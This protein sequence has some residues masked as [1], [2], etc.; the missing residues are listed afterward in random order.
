MRAQVQNIDPVLFLQ[1]ILSV[2]LS[3]GCLVY[4]WRT[5]RFR[6]VV[7]GLSAVAYWAAI[8]VKAVV[9]YASV[10]PVTSLYG[11]PSIQLALLLGMQTVVFEVGF[12]FALAAYGTR[13]W[14]LKVTDAVPVGIGLAL[15]ENGVL[16]GVF[17]LLNLAVIYLL[18]GSGSGLAGTIYN[19][20]LASAPAYFET[21]AALLPSVLL[22]SLERLSSMLAH[23][24]WGVLCVLAATT[25]KPRYLAFAL[26]MGLLDSLVPFAPGHIVLFEFVVFALSLLFLAVATLSLSAERKRPQGLEDR[27]ANQGEEPT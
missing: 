13:R 9:S 8:A 21:P 23:V 10:G 14:R 18:L 16:L 11:S 12:A 6:A 4:W 20:L 15:W 19:Q 7:L 25:G 24:A 26:P 2:A 5:R 17:S 27:L 1:P 3:F 22:G